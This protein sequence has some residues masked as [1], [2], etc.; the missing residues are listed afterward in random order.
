MNKTVHTVYI[1][2]LL[3]IGIAATLMLAVN[4]YNY[5][6]LSVE[7]RF[8]SAQHDLLKPS[9]AL[10]HGLGIIGTVMMIF[11]VSFYM[12]RKRVR[13]FFSYGY[14][15]HWLEMH[16]FLCTVGPVLVLFHTAFKFG[17]IVSISFWSMTAVV[18]S[19]FAGR[20]IY[21]QIPR[22]IKGNELSLQEIEELSAEISGKLKSIKEIP[23]SVYA[24]INAFS[25]FQNPSGMN[26]GGT[27]RHYI[28]VSREEKS[29]LSELRKHSG[30]LTVNERKQ[31][32]GTVRSQLNLTRRIG[33]LKVMHRL[34]NYWHIFHLPFAISMFVIM[35]IHVTVTIIFG[36][37]W[38]F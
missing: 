35:L 6:S 10:G 37:K 24:R 3:L 16:I 23:A 14:L 7:D 31:L 22:S 1:G 18:L 8:W 25:R 38:I 28:E 30:S 32:E 12:I 15:K 26:S 34:F 21:T 4:G 27:L 9:G 29:I 13:R 36:Y 5:Y 17:G 2:L 20:F 19:G 33:T 11:G